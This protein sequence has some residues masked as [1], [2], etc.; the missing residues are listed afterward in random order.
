MR[1]WSA[2]CS[3]GQEPYSI[4]MLLKDEIPDIQRKD[5]RILATDIS[6]TML[7]RAALGI[8]AKE[9][10]Q[11]LSKAVA[12]RHFVKLRNGDPGAVKIKDDIRGLVSFASLNLLG[13]W[14]MKGLFDVIF[15]GMS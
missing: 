11:G 2:A 15:C 1:I 5:V 13:K 9:Q 4:A 10:L 8:Y 14:P 6:M 3:S 12:Q 7:E